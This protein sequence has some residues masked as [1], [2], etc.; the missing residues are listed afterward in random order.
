MKT[1]PQFHKMK[2]S[3]TFHP[4]E[5]FPWKARIEGV[6]V[7]HCQTEEHAEESNERTIRAIENFQALQ[8]AESRLRSLRNS[9]FDTPNRDADIDATKEE[10]LFRRNSFQGF[11]VPALLK[12]IQKQ[13][14]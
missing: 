10:V 3:F 14:A 1:I 7:T 12:A 9:D 4:L 5:R 6:I 11:D 13:P 2:T 8:K